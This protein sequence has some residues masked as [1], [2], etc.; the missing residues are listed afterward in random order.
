VRVAIAPLT[1]IWLNRGLR[2]GSRAT[3]ISMLG[4][5]DALGQTV[6]GPVLGL[7]GTLRTVRSALVGVGL[8]LLPALGLY[9]RELVR[10]PNNDGREDEAA[11]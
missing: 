8:I 4:Q 11:D 7:V 5:S 9:G 2:P 6:G 10:T 1:L 3:V